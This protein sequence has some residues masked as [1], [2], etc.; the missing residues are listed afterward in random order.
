MKMFG[1]R[2]FYSLLIIL[3]SLQNKPDSL[4]SSD[5]PFSTPGDEIN[6]YVSE[7]HRRLLNC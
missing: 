7:T 6:F 1:Y 4:L 5:K 2:L 3:K